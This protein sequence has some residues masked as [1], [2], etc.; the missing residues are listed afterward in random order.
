MPTDASIACR[1]KPY[2]MPRPYATPYPASAD[3]IATCTR[4]TL[5]GQ[6]GKIVTTFISSSTTPAAGS[7]AWMSNAR[8]AVHTAKSWQIQPNVWKKIAPAAPSG[9][10]ITP[11]PSR[12]IATSRL[13]RVAPSCTNVSCGRRALTKANRKR[14]M[15]MQI[16]T[17]SVARAD[18][19]MFAVATTYSTS[20]TTGTTS[21]TRW[22]NTVPTSVGHAPF[23]SGI[24]RVS[25]ATRASSPILPGS[26][27]FAKSPTENAENTSGAAGCGGRN[28]E[29][30]TIVHAAARARTDKRLRAIET[31][32]H[33]H[34][35]DANASAIAVTLGP[36]QTN[37]AMSPARTGSPSATLPAVDFGKRNRRKTSGSFT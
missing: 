24:L 11:R 4:P 36:R 28:A 21:K 34:S 10:R 31:A 5:P 33:C 13:M 6:N 25:T 16:A 22:A 18:V 1:P 30:I 2:A 32:T 27:A 9:E 14:P 29:R 35:T 20:S 8:I 26:T 17:M 23:R 12:V 15:P 37:N 3:A 7:G 19:G